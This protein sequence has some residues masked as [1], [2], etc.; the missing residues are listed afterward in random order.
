MNFDSLIYAITVML[1]TLENG[2]L[3]QKEQV[4]LTELKEFHIP[5]K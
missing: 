4:T 5:L 1:P 3:T 2:G